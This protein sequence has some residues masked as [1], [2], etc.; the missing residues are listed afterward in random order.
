MGVLMCRSLWYDHI[1]ALTNTHTYAYTC[2]QIDF[3]LHDDD[4]E[5]DVCVCELTFNA[6]A[7]NVVR[8]LIPCVTALACFLLSR[9]NYYS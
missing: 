8:K 4:E 7:S 2:V 5:E 6:L 9:N 1:P 3:I